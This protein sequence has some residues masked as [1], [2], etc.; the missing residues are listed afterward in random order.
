MCK[1]NSGFEM[2][3][4]Y[5]LFLC[6]CFPIESSTWQEL[7]Y[8]VTDK[9]GN[10]R[11]WGDER[12]LLRMLQSRMDL[13]SDRH[14]VRVWILLLVR[15]WSLPQNEESG[16]NSYTPNESWVTIP[17]FGISLPPSASFLF[18]RFFLSL[19][20][21]NDKAAPLS[22]P[23]W[24]PKCLLSFLPQSPI[25]IRDLNVGSVLLLSEETEKAFSLVCRR[26]V[27]CTRTDTANKNLS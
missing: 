10:F 21:T 13:S 9:E 22:P 5:G 4:F 1:L 20:R 16:I 2:H 27:G 3:K 15:G 17:G 8:P 14:C 12:R 26:Y 11:H 24:S 23:L 7:R 6:I 25:S 19:C 18:G